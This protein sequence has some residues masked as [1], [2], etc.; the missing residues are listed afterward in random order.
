MAQSALLAV[1]TRFRAYQLGVAG[2]SFSYFA[3]GH[4]TLI[5]ATATEVSKPQLRAELEACKKNN[6]DTLHITSWDQDHCDQVGLQW[7]LENLRPRRIEYPGYLPHTECGQESLRIIRDYTA[8]RSQAGLQ[9][10]LQAIDPPY[11][12]SLATGS[13]LGYKDIVYHPKELFGSSNDNSTVKLF[14]AGCFNVLSLGDVEHVNIAALL[15]RCSILCREV[16]VMILAHHGADNGF[17][18]KRLLERLS[19]KVAICSSNYDNQ[20]DHPRQRIRD[21]LWEQEIRLYTTKTGDVLLASVGSHTMDYEAINFKANSTEVSSM[22][23]FRSRKSQLL[24]H[25]AD[26]YR[27]RFERP[28]RGPRSY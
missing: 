7:I 25:G 23:E 15:K 24:R 20:Y 18:T 2:S 11:V 21:L 28:N 5:E 13:A 14:R 1:P 27:N 22:K 17:T 19:P 4:F 26:A 12:K 3:G 9:A 16:D 10:A 8:R 6:I